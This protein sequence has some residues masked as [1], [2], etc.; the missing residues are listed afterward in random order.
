MGRSEQNQTDQTVWWATTRME[1]EVKGA[2]PMTTEITY[3]PSRWRYTE[4][5]YDVLIN[6]EVV[7]CASTNHG[8]EVVAMEVE[9]Q[10][11]QPRCA[12]ASCIQNRTHDDTGFC[13]YHNEEET[14]TRCDCEDS[15]YADAA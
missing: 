12:F 13:C 11:G 8:G 15:D 9:G 5:A 1:S 3:H 14:G 6:G 10:M 4:F 2:V 7:A